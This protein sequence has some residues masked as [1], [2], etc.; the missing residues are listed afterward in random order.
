MEPLLP[1]GTAPFGPP[2]KPRP[3]PQRD[4]PPPEPVPCDPPT[5]MAS[6]EAGLRVLFQPKEVYQKFSLMPCPGWGELV[7]NVLFWSGCGLL[8]A[9]A[10]A[11]NGSSINLGP[12]AM[13]LFL[14]GG[15]L[16]VVPVSFLLAGLLHILALMSGGK[17]GFGRSYQSVSLLG[18][19]APASAL[20]LCLPIPFVW[21]LP[22]LLGTYAAVKA[23]DTMHD[24]PEGPALAI[25][26]ICGG[27]VLL[28]QLLFMQ[29]L[30]R[31][32]YQMET[33][34]TLYSAAGK[35][36]EELA[37]HPL[38]APLS[39]PMSARMDSPESSF[40]M[41]ESEAAPGQPR[42]EGSPL[43]SSLDMLRSNFSGE[44]SARAQ[45]GPSPEQMQQMMEMG[46]RLGGMA[47]DAF[48]KNP[49]LLESMPPQQR[50]MIRQL[51]GQVNKYTGS[52]TGKGG[53][54]SDQEMVQGLQ[55]YLKGMGNMDLSAL[56]NM[57]NLPNT[58]KTPRRK[59]PAPEAPAPNS[60]LGA[61]E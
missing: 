25:V 17:Q 29:N 46:S 58:Q 11:L 10:A 45:Q 32:Q 20:L 26:G 57:K 23:V 39:S 28:G 4:A 7:L 6:M 34:A 51:L 8:L 30:K 38:T 41:V 22:T 50:A 2:G 24:A 42:Q 16:L 55:Q 18:S 13:L 53:Q 60:A 37:S 48:A 47:N 1:P 33:W 14:A 5:L 52:R 15:L 44:Q 61:E 56:Q 59:A 36:T 3:Q 31:L 54:M 27:V 12:V 21:V 49:K 40:P 9:F 43:P 19:L 35:L